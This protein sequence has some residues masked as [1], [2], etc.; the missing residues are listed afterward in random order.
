M[1]MG[2]HTAAFF[3]HAS[4]TPPFRGRADAT[5]C[6]REVGLETVCRY[7]VMMNDHFLDETWKQSK[8]LSEERC[9]QISCTRAFSDHVF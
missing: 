4:W 9:G 1:E 6:V 7:A 3:N 8:K 2:T 5:G